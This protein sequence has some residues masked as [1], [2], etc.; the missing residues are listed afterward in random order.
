MLRASEASSRPLER[1]QVSWVSLVLLLTVV[2]SVYLGKVWI[3]VYLVHY[4]VKH[5]VREYINRAVKT[6]NDEELVK[7][8]CQQLAALDTTE[9][10][11]EDGRIRRV[12]SVV[13][14]PS[15]VTWERDATGPALMLHVA[16]EY[17]RVVRYPWLNREQE[18]LLSV[19]LTEDISVPIWG[20]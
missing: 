9:E 3:P 10:E 16:F 20:K 4:E 2:G 6:R 14:Q 13:V 8:L 11:G 18:H 19:D 17:V 1:G 7:N 12:P 15:D 5:T